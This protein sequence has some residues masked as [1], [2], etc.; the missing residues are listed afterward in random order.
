MSILVL[1]IVLLVIFIIVNGVCLL[2]K[3]FTTTTQP[4]IETLGYANENDPYEYPFI[5]EN[6]LSEEHANEIIEHSRD[7]LFDS[8]VVGGKFTDIRN[9]QQTWILKNDPLV[10]P[11]FETISSMFNIPFENAEDLQVVHYGPGQYYNEHHDSCCD[12]NDKCRDFAKRGGQRII[13]VLIYLNN[14]FTEGNTYFKNLDLRVKPKVGDAI[15]FYPLAKNSNK[16]HPKAL[17]AGESIKSGE[18]WIANL[19]FREREFI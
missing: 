18:K 16:C 5:L 7:K 2:A 19:W 3:N 17:H 4:F 6:L 10:K 8:E 13:T 14:D 11:I 1:I 15:V 9:S 12:D